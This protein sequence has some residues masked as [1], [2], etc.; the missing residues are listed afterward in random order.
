MAENP[1][2]GSARKPLSS[3]DS[4]IQTDQIVQIKGGNPILPLKGGPTGEE[5]QEIA[6]LLSQVATL[7]AVHSSSLDRIELLKQLLARVKE[8]LKSANERNHTLQ[9]QLVLEKEKSAKLS[10]LLDPSAAESPSQAA[11]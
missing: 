4:H 8:E 2:L 11:S 5:G 10:A 1:L 3:P 9:Q 7:K 6:N